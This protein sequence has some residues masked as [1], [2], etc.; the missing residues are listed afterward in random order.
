MLVAYDHLSV[1]DVL[2]SSRRDTDYGI[3][4][5][6]IRQFNPYLDKPRTFRWR[7]DAVNKGFLA[8]VQRLAKELPPPGQYNISKSLIDPKRKYSMG[9]LARRSEFEEI[10]KR[11][12]HSPSPFHYKPVTKEKALCIPNYNQ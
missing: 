6:A 11:D 10:A 2:D 8:N 12:K 4:G 3:D 1:T 7:K 5:Y 9:K